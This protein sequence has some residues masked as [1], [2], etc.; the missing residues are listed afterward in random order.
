MVEGVGSV[1]SFIHCMYLLLQNTSTHTCTHTRAHTLTHTS[2]HTYTHCKSTSW[3]S[4]GHHAH[5]TIQTYFILII[6]SLT[7]LVNVLDSSDTVTVTDSGIAITM[8]NGMPKVYHL[9]QGAVSSTQH[10]DDG[11]SDGELC[12][13]G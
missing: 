5:N 4:R 9:S 12:C 13:Y 8:T 1:H 3:Q 11:R 7:G 10:D 2:S 6:L